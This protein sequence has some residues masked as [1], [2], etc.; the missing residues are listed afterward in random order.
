MPT[1]TDLNEKIK[2]Y[3][4]SKKSISRLTISADL[5][6]LKN[7]PNFAC[8]CYITPAELEEFRHLQQVITFGWTLFDRLLTEEEEQEE[9]D[10]RMM[11]HYHYEDLRVA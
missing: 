8:K 4:E 3:S 7:A 11:G 9:F 6:K 5:P 10:M 1:I 2:A